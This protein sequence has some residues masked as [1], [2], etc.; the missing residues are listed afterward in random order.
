[1]KTI[2]FK[3]KTVQPVLLIGCTFVY[4]LLYSLGFFLSSAQA[5]SK[6][7]AHIQIFYTQKPTQVYTEPHFD[8]SIVTV[9]PAATRLFTLVKIFEGKDGLGF[10]FKV[11]WEKGKYGYVLDTFVEPENKNLKIKTSYGVWSKS[12]PQ[13][14]KNRN[15]QE[16]ERES[17]PREMRSV[18]P[19][20]S[21]KMI[22]LGVSYLWGQDLNLGLA[23]N[24]F[25]GGQLRF[26]GPWL[27]II[28]TSVGLGA[29]FSFK[30]RTQ[31]YQ[32]FLSVPLNLMLLTESLYLVG[33]PGVELGYL[34]SSVDGDFTFGGK[35]D[36]GLGYTSPSWNIFLLGEYH[37]LG[38]QFWG[39]SLNISKIL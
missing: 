28:P 9:L 22:G 12:H 10:F 17:G 31:F 14:K 18:S 39:V 6:L 29:H 16:F 32:V 11:S 30:D 2:S 8:A 35:F 1:M 13:V 20:F 5:E 34:K 27:G 3:T 23:T 37:I 38:P 15:Q 26:D 21:H 19:L 4:L 36:L 7:P 24:E 33:A 25:A